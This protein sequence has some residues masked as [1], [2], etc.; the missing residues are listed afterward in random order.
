MPGKKLDDLDLSDAPLPT[1]PD[2]PREAGWYQ[3]LQEIDDLLSTGK[4]T[5]AQDTLSDIRDTIERTKRVS[6]GQ[7]RAIANIKTRGERPERGRGGRRYEGFDG[8]W[9]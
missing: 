2:D 8:R 9:R 1:E 5:W 7:Q 4:Y 3:A 6:D